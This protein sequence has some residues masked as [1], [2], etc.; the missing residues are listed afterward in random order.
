VKLGGGIKRWRVATLQDG[1]WVNIVPPTDQDVFIN[2]RNYEELS[3]RIEKFEQLL[4]ELT[5]ELR[6][7][8]IL[9]RIIAAREHLKLYPASCAARVR[10]EDAFK[11]L[12]EL[13][14]TEF[15]TEDTEVDATYRRLE[16]YVFAALSYE[17]SKTCCW[18]S[19][20]GDMYEIIMDYAQS[21]IDEAG[22]A[23]VEPVV[24]KA[25]DGGYDIWREHAANIGREELWVSW[26]EDESC[27]QRDVRDDVISKDYEIAPM[28]SL[29]E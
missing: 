7:E 12:Y 23:C 27:P 10:R 16:D 18:N 4:Q 25:T 9:E 6:R 8:G 2:S 26:S 3:G 24:F 14:Y 19:T 17:E 29:P 1:L 11:D 22:D 21:K 28:C 5:P 15:Y 20:T 13:E